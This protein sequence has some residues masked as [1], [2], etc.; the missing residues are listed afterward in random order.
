[1]QKAGTRTIVRAPNRTRGQKGRVNVRL[2]TGSPFAPQGKVRIVVKRGNRV[3]ARQVRKLNNDG[4]VST[5]F[6]KF[7]VGK[8]KVRAVYLGAPN[9]KRSAGNTT[10]RVTR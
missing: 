5:G 6:R 7:A 4:R 1:V 8:F 2:R 10:F 3:V 9:F